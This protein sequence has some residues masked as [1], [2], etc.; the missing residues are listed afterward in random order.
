MDGLLIELIRSEHDLIVNYKCDDKYKKKIDDLYVD[1]AYMRFLRIPDNLDEVSNFLN[2]K[3]V[4][5]NLYAFDV[6]KMFYEKLMKTRPGDIEIY[7]ESAI[8]T[9]YKLGG[10]DFL[11]IYFD[12]KKR[13]LVT[14]Y[15]SLVIDAS[16]KNDYYIT[17]VNTAENINF[18]VDKSI[19]FDIFFNNKVD[20]FYDFIK[21]DENIK[22]DKYL[23]MPI[24]EREKI[25][26]KEKYDRFWNNKRRQFMKKKNNKK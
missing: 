8:D 6:S 12:N 26:N 1:D 5:D 3:K 11:Y 19:I 21:L 2:L 25:K 22:K 17:G 9:I 18:N 4:D 23:S 7:K 10:L 16:F 24:E 15:F 13:K 14:G 20:D